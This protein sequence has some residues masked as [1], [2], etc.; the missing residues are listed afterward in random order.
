M[1][2]ILVIE[3]D[4][5]AI[6]DYRKIIKTTGHTFLHVLNYEQAIERLEKKNIDIIICSLNMNPQSVKSI[7]NLINNQTSTIPLIIITEN[8]SIEQA[9][10]MMKKGTFEYMVKPVT[11]EKLEQVI[12]H[13]A[14]YIDAK[15]RIRKKDNDASLTS[16]MDGVIGKSKVMYDLAQRVYKTAYN[17]SN[18]LIY[19]ESG[20]GKE[21]IARYIH[22]KSPRQNNPFIPLDCSALPHTLLESELFGYE[23]GAFTGA[24]KFKPGILDQADKGTL[25]LDEITELDYQFQ[26]KLLRFI[27]EKQFRRIGGMKM[28]QVDIRILSATNRE[29]VD[30]IKQNILRKDL[31]YRINVITI[32]VPALRERKEDIPLLVQYFINDFNKTQYKKIT[33]VSDETMDCLLTY[34]WPGNIRELHNIVEL[35]CVL[36]DKT[37]L[38]IDNLPNKFF[39]YYNIKIDDNILNKNYHEAKELYLNDFCKHYFQQLLKECNGNISKASRIAG[40]SRKSIYR[41]LNTLGLYKTN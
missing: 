21:L 36:S 5:L 16:Y 34:D 22:A 19:G 9:V 14:Q 29:P 7:L 39:Q 28:N 40:L 20:T 12:T 37:I 33:G 24:D 4:Q 41:M 31:Y 17:N 27:Q 6:D 10:D 13:A 2:K 32:R 15:K 8:E 11:F 25:F 1:Y 38:E 23:K 30:A 26:V 35:L 18:V 3:N